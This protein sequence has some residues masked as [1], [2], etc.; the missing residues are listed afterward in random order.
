MHYVRRSD[1]MCAP[2][3]SPI[4]AQNRSK[5]AHFNDFIYAPTARLSNRRQR[6]PE[7]QV[8]V[9]QVRGHASQVRRDGVAK[10]ECGGWHAH[11]SMRDFCALTAADLVLTDVSRASFQTRGIA[12]LCAAEARQRDPLLQSSIDHGLHPRF[13]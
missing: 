5:V 7:G 6:A 4:V 9:L 13:T 1:R 12:E 11:V 3:A 8:V 2:L 10:S